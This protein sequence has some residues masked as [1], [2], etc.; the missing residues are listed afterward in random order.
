MLPPDHPATPLFPE[1]GVAP[2][3]TVVWLHCGVA[4]RQGGPR[5]E[6]A[7]ASVQVQSEDAD[8]RLPRHGCSGSGCDAANHLEDAIGSAREGDPLDLDEVRHDGEPPAD[9]VRVCASACLLVGLSVL[10]VCYLDHFV[11][12]PVW[13]GCITLLP[14]CGFHGRFCL[15]GRIDYKVCNIYII[16]YVPYT[17]L[18]AARR[19][20]AGARKPKAPWT[21]FWAPTSAWSMDRST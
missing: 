7:R 10:P 12:P 11:V 15:L 16:I 2:L 14:Q 4:L 6:G 21:R 8:A 13:L 18:P 5:G 17:R 19:R 1:L 3:A 20:L 9:S